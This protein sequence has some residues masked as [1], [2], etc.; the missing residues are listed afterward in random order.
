MDLLEWIALER[1]HFTVKNMYTNIMAIY[2]QKMSASTAE[3]VWILRSKNVHFTMPMKN[4][5]VY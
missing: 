4:S 1:T 5:I 3:I 2:I